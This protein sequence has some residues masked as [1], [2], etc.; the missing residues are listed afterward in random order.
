MNEFNELNNKKKIL[1]YNCNY[2]TLIPFLKQILKFHNYIHTSNSNT[3]YK[4]DNYLS[5]I[6]VY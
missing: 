6:L 5:S 3:K 2:K 1:H 4:N